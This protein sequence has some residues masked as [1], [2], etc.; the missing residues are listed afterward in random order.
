MPVTLLLSFLVM[1]QPVDSLEALRHAVRSA[2]PGDRVTLAAGTYSGTLWLEAI[3]GAQGK[4]IVIAGADPADPPVIDGEAE[5]IHL[6]MCEWVSIEHMILKSATGNGLNVDD[7]GNLREPARGI[8]LRSLVV[9][10][11]GPDGNC[12]GIKL[13]G[14]RDFKVLECT[15]ER[16]GGGGSGID[17]V[18]CAEGVIES[19]TLR[20]EAG[21]GASGIQLKGGTHTVVVRRCHFEEAGQRALNI[22]GSTGLSFF[23]PE[24]RGFE[25]RAIA[26]EGCT[27]I[28]SDAAVAFVGVDGARVER[29]TIYNPRRWV[30]RILQETRQEGFVPSRGGVLS[31]NL[32]VV[33]DVRVLHPNIGD[34]TDP[35]SF[36]FERNFWYCATDA[37][38]ST[39]RLP[40][41]EIE[42]VYGQDPKL[43]DPSRG[44]LRPQAPGVAERV[45]AASFR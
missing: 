30:L 3:K 16:W 40:S 10:D 44:D 6:S 26:V 5:C 29:N 20:H 38:H 21:K 32:V 39:P 2:A 14:L 8:E 24:P 12:D 13:S 27:I 19:C 34:G 18:G 37:K 31:A 17:L 43:A 23:R 41:P 15:I 45:G 28:G 42:G 35:A 36:V 9:Q 4:P 22:G 25:A 1:L 33:D 7:G 11:I